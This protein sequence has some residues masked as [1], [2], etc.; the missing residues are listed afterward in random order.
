MTDIYKGP[1]EHYAEV[2]RLRIE[3]CS[4]GHA[5]VL[6]IAGLAG[7]GIDYGGCPACAAIERL[8]PRGL[9]WEPNQKGI[10]LIELMIVIALILIVASLVV[11]YVMRPEGGEIAALEP[12]PREAW[13]DY[14]SACAV[15][16][17]VGQISTCAA[18]NSWQQEIIL[19]PMTRV[20]TLVGDEKP[21][22]RF[23]V[24]AYNEDAERMTVGQRIAFDE[25]NIEYSRPRRYGAR[26]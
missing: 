8:S 2:S 12:H 25:F 5:K 6:Y 15:R 13:W 19:D 21:R 16:T 17:T 14:R 22:K 4:D 26:R 20:V 7:A 11:P 3:E 9:A 1:P 10:T 24:W 18:W 23:A